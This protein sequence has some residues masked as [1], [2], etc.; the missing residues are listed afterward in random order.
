VAAADL[1]C[2]VPGKLE[3]LVVEQEEA[4]EP[5][6]VDQLQLL[7]QPPSSTL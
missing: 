7:V 1:V 2:D 3:H 4:C 6:L 5:E